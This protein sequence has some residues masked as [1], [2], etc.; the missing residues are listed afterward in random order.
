MTAGLLLRER[1]ARSVAATAATTTDDAARR[2]AAHRRR[3]GREP[4]ADPDPVIHRRHD[5]P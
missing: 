5:P 4:G 1:E 2:G 3:R